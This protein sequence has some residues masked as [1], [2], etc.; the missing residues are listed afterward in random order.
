MSKQKL[1]FEDYK[2]RI[3]ATKQKK[4]KKKQLER[5]EVYVDRCRGNHKKIIKKSQERF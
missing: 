4:K 5:N 2:H 1:K 3:E